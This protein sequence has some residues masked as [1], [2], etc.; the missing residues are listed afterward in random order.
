MVRLLYAKNTIFEDE[1][2]MIFEGKTYQEILD[3]MAETEEKIK[4]E[5]T[6]KS[7]PSEGSVE[8]KQPAAAPAE[9]AE[10]SAEQAEEQAETKP[11]EGTDETTEK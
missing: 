8:E 11:D 7:T 3:K 5:Y 4:S 1:V 2:N 6:K 10:K 9:S